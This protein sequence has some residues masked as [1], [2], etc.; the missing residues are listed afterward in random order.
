V[1][2][3]QAI[4]ADLDGVALV[5]EHALRSAYEEL[6]PPATVD[7]Y[8]RATYSPGS[9]ANRLAD[10]PIFVVEIDGEVCSFADA[11]IQDGGIVIAEI[12]TQ[13]NWRRQGCA[14]SLVQRLTRLDARLPLS[15]DVLLGNEAGERFYE[16]LDFVPGETVQMH[17]FDTAVV[18][19]RWWHPPLASSGGEH[20]A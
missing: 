12:C 19:R 17:M 13:P 8:L 4:R 9:M 20:D 6:L 2:I 11:F 5:A 18:E 10:H 7:R 16:S 1:K 3:R 14:R 15:A